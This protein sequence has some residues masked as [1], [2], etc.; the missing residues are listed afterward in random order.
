MLALGL[1]GIH[2][3]QKLLGALLQRYP[4]AMLI[5]DDVWDE[6]ASASAL[7]VVSEVV[8]MQEFCEVP[9]QV[10][11]T[12]GVQMEHYCWLQGALQA[13]CTLHLPPLG[14][15]FGLSAILFMA[16]LFAGAADELR[17]PRPAGQL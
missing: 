16:P 4:D 12:V 6:G 11:P 8:Q 17:L 14:I 2:G 1:A 7:S 15:A 10:C 5:I 3:A 13:I 9:A